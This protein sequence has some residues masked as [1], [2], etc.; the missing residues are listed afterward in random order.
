MCI[1]WFEKGRLWPMVK[2]FQACEDSRACRHYNCQVL[3]EEKMP[4]SVPWFG[5]FIHRRCH[6]NL[7]LLSRVLGISGSIYLTFVGCTYQKWWCYC[8]TPGLKALSCV[9]ADVHALQDENPDLALNGLIGQQQ[10]LHVGPF[11]GAVLLKKHSC[12]PLLIKKMVDG[13]LFVYHRC[14]DCLLMPCSLKDRL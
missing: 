10:R 8:I 2:L 3:I 13:W 11:L 5:F 1:Y 14:L 12:S 7:V 4:R 9:C 6:C